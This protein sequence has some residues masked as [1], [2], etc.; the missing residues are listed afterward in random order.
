MKPRT[1]VNPISKKR[2]A[3][4]SELLRGNSTIL[5]S[6]SPSRS[7]QTTKTV[8]KPVKKRNAKRAKANHERAYGAKR[9]WIADQPCAVCGHLAPSDPAHT[10]GDGG[11][12]HK[13]SAKYLIPLCRSRLLAR[14]VEQTHRP[15]K[16]SVFVRQ[17]VVEEWLD[18]C[19][20]D[21]HRIGV[22]SFEAKHNV[23]LVALAEKYER[24]WQ[25]HVG[26]A[27]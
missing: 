17:R 11:I 15:S 4:H 3:A 25:A 22:K 18:G 24:L 2:A 5:R 9:D 12:G 21:S 7:S 1:R 10:K 8:R 27:A 13:S 16:G 6:S 23:S 14:A 26:G 20:R 19:H